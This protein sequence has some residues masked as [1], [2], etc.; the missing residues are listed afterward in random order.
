MTGDFTDEEIFKYN[1]APQEKLSGLSPNQVFGLIHHAFQEESYIQLNPHISFEILDK[2][3]FFRLCEALLK[4]IKRDGFVKL[5][6]LGSLTKK[7]LTEL[8]AHKF[9]EEYTIESGMY[10]LYNEDYLFSIRTARIV[11]EIS[12][13]TKKSKGKLLL[14]KQGEKHLEIENRV[15]LF[16]S[17]FF[18]FFKNYN[19]GYHD[20]HVDEPV[21]QYGG[22]FTIYLLK[23]YGDQYR[24]LS[25]Y[26]DKYLAVFY[27][28][29][30]L[31]EDGYNSAESNFRSCYN[32]RT[33]RYFTTWFGLT[34]YDA[35][36]VFHEHDDA[37][38]R[39]S[40]ILDKLFIFAK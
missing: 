18:I 4:I 24:E 9:I 14:T 26:A 40:A 2:I 33:F 11:C 37:K 35:K 20:G 23:K 38:L 10:K 15:E 5:T 12:S 6:P 3:P 19:W 25:F 27:N 17:I 36:Y 21:G 31:F 7:V 16:K 29:L 22:L 30:D 34:T 32:H 8:Y 39:K 28:F 1:N 13:F